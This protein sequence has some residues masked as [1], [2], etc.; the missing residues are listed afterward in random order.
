MFC[1]LN[2]TKSSESACTVTSTECVCRA[3]IVVQFFWG[4]SLD[5][6]LFRALQW[7]ILYVYWGGGPILLVFAFSVI[8]IESN[9]GVLFPLVTVQCSY[10]ISCANILT[11]N[12]ELSSILGSIARSLSPLHN[13]CIRL[14]FCVLY[15]LAIGVPIISLIWYNLAVLKTASPSMT[16][17]FMT[18]LSNT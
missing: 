14:L 3:S 17:L 4:I 13:L 15:F 10:L 8:P 12:K 2:F 6:F 7:W 5:L 18:L 9:P 1:W 16:F 11:N